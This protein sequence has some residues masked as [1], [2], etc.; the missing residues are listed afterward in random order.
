MEN[1]LAE[2]IFFIIHDCYELYNENF[3]YEYDKNGKTKNYSRIQ[4]LETEIDKF[5]SLRGFVDESVNFGLLVLKDDSTIYKI[6]DLCIAS[7]FIEDLPKAISFIKSSYKDDKDSKNKIKNDMN[8]SCI[9]NY[10]NFQED[11]DIN[12]QTRSITRFILIYNSSKNAVSY[13]NYIYDENTFIKRYSNHYYC[14]RNLDLIQIIPKKINFVLDIVF[15]HNK[16]LNDEDKKKC[17][18]IYESLNKMKTENWISFEN[19]GNLESFKYYF[20]I[21]IIN[22]SKR[23]SLKEIEL[24][25]ENSQELLKIQS[26]VK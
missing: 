25:C 2:N 9:F 4:I 11:F 23:K 18:K 17:M 6:I 1:I 19:S 3:F 10:V 21:L 22:S 26:V 8:I 7:K 12:S 20:N 15:L 24:I 16:I 5:V 13:E 14:L